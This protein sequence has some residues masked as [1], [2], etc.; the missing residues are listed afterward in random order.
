MRGNLLAINDFHGAI[1]PPTGSAGLVNGVPAG[2]AEYLATYVKRLRADAR[3]DH[4]V[5]IT[6]GAG[7][8]VGGSPLTSAA[9]HDDPAV[10]LL[11]S[12]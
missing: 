9:F 12:I 1:D 4:R 2:G 10:E 7:D 8:M 11:N 6:V 5:S 3:R